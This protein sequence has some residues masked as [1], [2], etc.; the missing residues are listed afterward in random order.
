MHRVVE[1][2]SCGRK[3]RV[4]DAAPGRLRC[5]ACRA[6]LPWLVEVGDD[7]FPD[8]VE[9]SR[10]PVLVDVW[11]PW[12]GPCRAV[13]PVVEQLARER[14]GKLKVAKVNSDSSPNV[15]ARH[16]ISSIPTLLLYVDGKE[17]A[18][19]VGA[20]PAPALRSWVDGVLAGRS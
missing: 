11:A 1:C 14:A 13:A 2:P 18:R 4:P 17:V 10:L 19:S 16:R 8:V 3:N 15:S 7:R 9:R 12:C 6:D 20:Q 5:A